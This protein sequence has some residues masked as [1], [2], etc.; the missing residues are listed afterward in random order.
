MGGNSRLNTERTAGTQQSR[1]VVSRRELLS[2]FQIIPNRYTMLELGSRGVIR[3]HVPTSSSWTGRS[4][5]PRVFHSAER[6]Q[7]FNWDGITLAI[8]PLLGSVRDYVLILES[9]EPAGSHLFRDPHRALR[10]SQQVSNYLYLRS[11]TGHGHTVC[12][13]YAAR[14]PAFESRMISNPLMSMGVGWH[15]HQRRAARIYRNRDHSS[16][17]LD[18]CA[19]SVP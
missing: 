17:G 8:S 14:K 6:T 16:S 9:S 12:V 10:A 3:F 2:T 13:T 19:A 4:G 5:S 15:W 11:G 7:S 1:Q 18:W